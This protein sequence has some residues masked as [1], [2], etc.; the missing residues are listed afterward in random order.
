MMGAPMGGPMGPAGPRPK[1]LLPVKVVMILSIVG[2]AG[3]VISNIGTQAGV[4]ALAGLGS[5]MGLASLGTWVIQIIQS[6]NL[7]KYTQNSGFMWWLS[8]IPCVNIW[9]NL[10]PLRE[11][12]RK[13]RQMSGLNPELKHWAVYLFLPAWGTAADMEDFAEK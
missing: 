8:I 1:L 2:I 4:M 7:G 3:N 10:A 9:F 6:L 13:A 5:L 11:E 12:M